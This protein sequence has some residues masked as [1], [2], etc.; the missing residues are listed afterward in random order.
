M[1]FSERQRLVGLWLLCAT[2][3]VLVCSLLY[4]AVH[5]RG[6]Y[7]PIGNDSFY[8]ARRILDT[9]ANP[10]AFYQ[11]DP[12]IH[13][14]EGSLLVWPWGYDYAMGWL[15]RIGMMTGITSQPM[16]IL[17]WIPVAAVLLSVA[18]I[19][20][21]A[22]RLEL[23]LWSAALAGLCVAFSPLTQVLHGV[24]QIDHHYAEYIF[25]LATVGCGLQW[26]LRPNDGRAAAVL[27]IV[28]GLAQAVQNGLFILQLPVILVAFLWWV[29]NL[30]VP[31]RA[32]AIFSG[33]LLVTTIL[34]L[35]PSLPFQLGRFEFYTLSWFHL[36]IAFG[37]V[38]CVLL[39]SALR[40]SPRNFMLM[41]GAGFV[42][43][44]PL[45]HQIFI[46]HSFLIGSIKRLDAISEMRSVRQLAAP[47]GGLMF[48]ASLYSM[49]IWLWPVTTAYSIY[50]A[51][52]DRASGRLFFWVC[53]VCGLILLVMQFRMHYF[54]SLALFMPW[55]VATEDLVRR[56][57]QHRKTIML[58][59]SLVLLVMFIPPLRFYLPFPPQPAGDPHFPGLRLVLDDLK[60]A[61]EKEPG[62]VLADNDA[63]HYIRFYTDCSV[64][65]DNFILTHQQTE[66]IE[67]IDYLT[68]LSPEKLPAAAPYVRYLLLRPVQVQDTDK[69][70]EYT[71]YSQKKA[72]LITALL[73]TPTDQVHAPYVLMREAVM[74]V[75]TPPKSIPFMRLYKVI[76][77]AS[78][79][80]I[81]GRTGPESSDASRH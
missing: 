74:K 79:P 60:K 38:V 2:L 62:V 58:A 34:V 20:L 43:L 28:L 7:I 49:L 9:A 36:Y 15:V 76:P 24:G 53:A 59:A 19:M 56:R 35:L 80:A 65:A 77:E 51:W 48:I 31:L 6:E 18:L 21:I 75:G 23:S 16:A 32:A 69:G 26:F 46:A 67:Q 12:K 57:S 40:R 41:A 10:S 1:Q 29:Q 11:F 27:G 50:R 14:P 66:K 71:S 22:R 5:F 33:S 17:I 30:R 45:L 4:P 52:T 81:A 70:Y 44:L 55:L 54:G 78:A 13:A 37:T 68:S 61:C 63:G 3:A 25:V 73:L 39:M 72:P 47:A 42:L 8:H 64:I